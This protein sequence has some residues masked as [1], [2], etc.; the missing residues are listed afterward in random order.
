MRYLPV[1]STGAIN[2]K[3]SNDCT[4]RALANASNIPYKSAH[5]LLKKHGRKSGCGCNS[6]V[7]HKAYTEAGFKLL[8]L[9]GT[10][11]RTRHISKKI[12]VSPKSG[13]SIGRLLPSLGN[14]RYIV[15]ITG[16][17]LA[18]VDGNIIDT[19]FSK[20]GASVVALYRKL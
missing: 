2:P 4:V 11:A 13:I 3:E 15:V 16:H 12:G 9:Y 8:G 5:D 14:G 7:W 20:S 6:D 19:G 18:I 1:S 10:T 17:A